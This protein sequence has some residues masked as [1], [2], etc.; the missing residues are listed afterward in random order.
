MN[1][2]KEN[3]DALNAVVKV[4]ITAEDYKTKVED[5][6]RDYRKK[7]NIPGFRKGRVPMGMVKRQF[8]KSVMIDEVNKLLQESLNKF[9]FEEKLEILGNPLP[10]ISDTFS[11][12]TEPLS[13]EFELGL[14]PEFGVNLKP[15]KKIIHYNIITDEALID[16]EL[17][18]MQSHSGKISAVEVIGEKT[19]VTG[20]FVNEGEQIEKRSTVNLADIKGKS[21]LKK[22]LGS[23]VGDTIELKTKGLFEDD[24]KLQSALGISSEKVKGLNIKIHFTIEETTEIELADLD[25]ELFDNFF[26]D[27]SVKTV[28]ELRDKIKEDSEKQFQQQADQQLLNAIT[29]HFIENT[30][31]DLPA[32]FLQKWLVT[33]GEK[34]LTTEEAAEEYN[35]SE[36]GLRYQLIQEKIISD[37]NIKIDYNE[38]KEFAKSFVRTQT[39]QFGNVNPEELELED[40]TNRILSDQ[41]GVQRL[42][43]QLMSK[44]L[45][46]F[47][48]KNMSFKVKNVTFENFIKEVYKSGK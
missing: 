25:Q 19:L 3:V 4:D 6:L 45:L 20:T 29:E 34:Q 8:G 18:N 7:A 9:L 35:K 24:Y 42:Q 36:K 40:I 12:D 2:T 32:E 43:N 11:W 48:K 26:P 13:F 5:I 27:G 10:K 44:K 21:H 33:I 15:K 1:I 22:L 46:E 23:K 16:K 31:F 41:E 28:T 37:H 17:E 47:Y 39:A 14:V 38:L 30:K